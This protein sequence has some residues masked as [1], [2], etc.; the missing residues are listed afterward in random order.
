MCVLH[1]EQLSVSVLGVREEAMV[2]DVI[3]C[4]HGVVPISPL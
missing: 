1:T 2:G 3:A 4:H